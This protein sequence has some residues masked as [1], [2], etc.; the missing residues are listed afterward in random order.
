MN[1]TVIA[2]DY[3]GKEHETCA[4]CGEGHAS[5]AFEMQA[6]EYGAGAAAVTLHARVPVWTC[7]TC[8]MQYVGEDGEVAQHAAVCRH[9]GLLAPAEIKAIR[10]GAGRKQEEFAKDIG[11]GIASLKRWENG[12]V[13]QNQIADQA[14]RRFQVDRKRARRIEPTFRTT[15]DDAQFAAAAHFLPRMQVYASAAA[16]A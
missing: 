3:A 6:F 5:R 14:I 12:R 10:V 15:F 7:D 16:H 4:V 9:L 2:S 11:C 1:K 8:E 13:I